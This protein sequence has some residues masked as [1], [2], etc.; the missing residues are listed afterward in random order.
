MRN[1]VVAG[2]EGTGEFLPTEHGAIM[3]FIY[4]TLVSI[5]LLTVIALLVALAVRKYLLWQM[6]N[7]R[8]SISMSLLHNIFVSNINVFILL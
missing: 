3:L 8:V 7:S 2:D 5:A 1:R 4:V 6:R